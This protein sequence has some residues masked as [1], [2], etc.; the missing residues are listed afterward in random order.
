MASSIK[1]KLLSKSINFYNFL[2]NRFL[3]QLNKNLSLFKTV[4]LIAFL[5]KT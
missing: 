5:E 3:L 2:L 1:I 4:D